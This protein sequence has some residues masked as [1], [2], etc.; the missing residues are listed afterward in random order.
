M[1]PLPDP[2]KPSTE[3][4]LF[5][6]PW[7]VRFCLYTHFPGWSTKPTGQEKKEEG[8]KEL[9]CRTVC[10]CWREYI[11]TPVKLIWRAAYG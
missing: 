7:G 9:V 4:F 11:P 8:E 5:P 1:V 6:S 3:C 2:G 10:V